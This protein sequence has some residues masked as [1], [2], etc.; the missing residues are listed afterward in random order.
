MSLSHQS[1]R[2]F[3]R[4]LA[5]ASAA[6]PLARVLGAAE[7]RA[8]TTAADR[9][10]FFY[11]PDGMH[12]AD[13]GLSGRQWAA[14]GP[15]QRDCTLLSGVRM[16]DDRSQQGH[17][18]GAKRLLCGD[19]SYD[20]SLDQFLAKGFGKASLFP[21]LYLGAAATRQG[22]I[23]PDELISW[24]QGTS[25]SPEDSPLQA[26]SRLFPNGATFSSAG[27]AGGG[28]IAPV[29]PETLSQRASVLDTVLADLKDLRSGLPASEQ[30]KLDRHIEATRAVE[31]RVQTLLSPEPAPT[32]ME[33]TVDPAAVASCE[34]SR[35]DSRG[36]D[37]SKLYQADR[38]PD[39][40][41]AQLDVLAHALACGATRVATL[42]CSHHTSDLFMP[43]VPS[44]L[45]QQSHEASHNNQNVYLAQR[46][47][48]MGQL[49]GFL[50]RLRERPDPYVSGATLLD[51]TL[52]LFC[53]E[54]N[55]G[56][57]HL[58]TDMPFVLAG[59]QGKGLRTGTTLGLDAMHHRLHGS[60]ISMLG[61]SSQGFRDAP[62]ALPQLGG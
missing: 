44:D 24:D 3:L 13:W 41:G 8:A 6:W 14:L 42:Q 16:D 51:R 23:K 26:F 31:L 39:V 22:T 50:D 15:R 1:R 20:T 57:S 49:Q 10:V 53:T 47:W 21:H 46:V 27:G 18:G 58:Y 19:T 56:P 62:A 17:P 54:I 35:L 40:L 28:V 33:P 37:A 29:E 36:L 4:M 12:E 2:H 55:W 61:A 7:A 38:F 5:G 59:G 32:G 34:A 30:R 9:I 43:F 11:V 60:L 48:W 25:P 45:K 52:V